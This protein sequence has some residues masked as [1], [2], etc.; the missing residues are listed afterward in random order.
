[1]KFEKEENHRG[2]HCFFF[3]KFI[4]IS[5][6]HKETWDAS[7]HLSV[8]LRNILM[9]VIILKMSIRFLIIE[10]NY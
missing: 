7:I 5:F 6:I 9:T 1:M 8:L 3:F 2:M 4:L 10:M